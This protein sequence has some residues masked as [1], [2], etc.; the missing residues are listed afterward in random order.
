MSTAQV[1]LL[2]PGAITAAA[3]LA[4]ACAFLDGVVR[5]ALRARATHKRLQ[6]LKSARKPWPAWMAW[7]HR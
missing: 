2:V 3:G 6:A 5:P 7:L 1:L 4:V